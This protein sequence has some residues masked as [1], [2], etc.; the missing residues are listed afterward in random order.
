MKFLLDRFIAASWVLLVAEGVCTGAG[1]GEEPKVAPPVAPPV[2]SPPPGLPPGVLAR[3]N[4]KDITLDDYVGYLFASLGKSRLDEFVDRL[5]VE[6]EAKT[7]GVVIAP[8]Q[9]ETALE[10]RLDRTVK[11]LYQGNKDSFAESLAKRRTSLEEH[12]AKLRQDLYYEMLW[13]EVVLKSRQVTDADVERQFERSYGEGGVLYTLRH[14]LVSARTAGTVPPGSAAGEGDPGAGGP[15]ARTTAEARE[16]AEK[17]LKEIQGGLDFVQA[18][19]L[20]SDDAFTKKNE[21]RIPHY[22]KG[23]YSDAFHNAV[24]Q[25]TPESPQSGVVESPRGFHILQLVEKQVTKLDQV[26]AD[27]EK[28]VK[29]QVPTVK[30]RHEL[31]SRLRAKSRVEGL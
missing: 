13:S 30:E 23:F 27:L 4:G 16:R 29:T 22:R 1:S 20:Y 12:R 21:G 11:G 10:E 6:E 28:V 7:L 17:I 31:I 19:K 25:L 5:L 3:V 2:V 14:I 8:Q 15:S 18:V 24:T 9:V 26:R